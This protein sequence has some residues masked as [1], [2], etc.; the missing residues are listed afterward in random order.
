[1]VINGES[2]SN[3]LEFVKMRSG[4]ANTSASHAGARSGRTVHSM[5]ESLVTT[6]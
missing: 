4:S 5:P 1:M 3:T 6:N 2:A